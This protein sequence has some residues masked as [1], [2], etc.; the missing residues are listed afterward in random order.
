MK[1]NILLKKVRIV[2]EG[3][4]DNNKVLD[5]LIENGIIKKIGTNIR[6][7]N[8]VEVFQEKGAHVS[9][10]WMDIGV[11]IGE[12]GYEHREDLKSITKAAIKGGYT[13]I[14]A[15]P[16]THP[17]IQDKTSVQFL[18]SFSKNNPVE[19]F[20]IGALSKDAKGTE[21]TE[22]YDMHQNGAI[23][24]SD[25]DKSIQSAA[26][27][28]RS[29][30]YVKAFGGLVMNTPMDYTLSKRGMM[31]EGATST[32]M[33]VSGI[34]EIAEIIM[35]ERD[36]NLL[37]YSES[38]L[39]IS[40]ISTE[41]GIKLIRKAK[42]DSLKVTASTSVMNLAFTDKELENFDS[43][44]KVMPPLRS[45]LDRKALRKAIS[46]GALD[47]IT[48]NHVPIEEE[49]KK[50]E[51]S[52]AKF[53]AIGLETCFAL[54][55]T[56]LQKTISLGQLID[57]LSYKPRT[58]FGLPMPKIEVGAVANLTLF[59]PTRSWTVTAA[60]FASKSRN[61]P[62]LGMELMGVVFGVVV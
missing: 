61:S 48:S 60:D 45:R 6:N 38:R 46:S 20:A 34:S 56:T 13:A 15:Y 40:N 59:D 44:Y 16:N 50:L 55:N 43:M 32:I 23:A 28:L 22:M 27:M 2:D 47:I 26:V 5:I 37:K 18:K 14:A 21:I 62:L 24:F 35:I 58:L 3:H 53:G 19:I 29:L 1:K 54:A 42:K 9:I 33:G 25:G 49:F 30:E 57:I 7:P 31:H 4:S 17:V 36:L 52:Y 8:G 10:G 39:H 41:K 12:P 11:Q 51:F